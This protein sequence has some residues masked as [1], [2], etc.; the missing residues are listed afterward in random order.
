MYKQKLYTNLRKFIVYKQTS[1]L[2]TVLL[3][4]SFVTTTPLV[5]E[6]AEVLVA[7]VSNPRLKELLEEG[8]RQVDAGDY[9]GAIATYQ[10][11]A[12][13]DTRNAKIHSGIGYL[14]AQ[15]GNFQLALA[16]YRRAIAIDPNNS[17]FY[18]AVGYVKG[19]LGDTSGAKEAY[20]RAI[21]LNRGN[22]N[23]YLGL[24]VTQTSL[25]DYESAKWA[26]EQAISLDNNNARTYEL[27]GSM[28]KQ[29][30]QTQQASNVLQK[31]FNLYRRNNDPEGMNRVQALLQ[32]IGG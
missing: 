20:R 13:I 16:A 18:Y 31:A 4:G 7:Q 14:Y 28:F 29:R 30:R 17:D 24:G 5:A 32:E 22:V 1:F 25:G 12:S 21:Q 9:S 26:Y 11:A 19:N 27:M 23:A 8:R 3:I 2:V 10:Q 6:G 15:Q